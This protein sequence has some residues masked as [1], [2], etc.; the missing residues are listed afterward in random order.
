MAVC[1]SPLGEYRIDLIVRCFVRSQTWIVVLGTDTKCTVEMKMLEAGLDAWW[2]QDQQDD[3]LA[4]VDL[5]EEG[6]NGSSVCKVLILQASGPEFSLQNSCRKIWAWWPQTCNPR[7]REA[8]TGGFLKL[9]GQ[10]A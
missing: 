8:D 4:I 7:A 9:T 1:T 5:T 2:E 3:V 10:L 6:W